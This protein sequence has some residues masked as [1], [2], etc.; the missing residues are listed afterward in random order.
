MATRNIKAGNAYVE[1]GIRNRVAAGAKAVQADLNKLSASLQKHGQSIMRLG[2][3][4]S[5]AMAA[6]L[7][8]AIRAASEMQETMGKFNVV[9][10]EAA[11]NMRQWGEETANAMGVSER[12]MMN[13]LSSMQDL[14]VPMGV[15]PE[16]ARDMSK[17]LSALAVD[18][19]SF[20]NM[21]PDKAFEDL[22][23][24]MTGSGEVMKKYGV[25]LSQ[26]AVNQ[27]LLQNSIDPKVATE[28]EKAQ[29]RLTIIMRGTTAAQGDAIRT[30][31][32]FANRMKALGATLV[33]IT[34]HLGQPLLEPLAHLIGH[35]KAAASGVKD[36]VKENQD[37]V[38]V[39]GMAM[40]AVGGLG[41]ALVGLGGVLQVVGMGLG[42]L[43]AGIGLLI[44]PVGLALGAVTALA[45]GLV[46]YT[47]IGM[48]AIDALAERFGPL[49]KSVQEAVAGISKALQAGDIKG[50]WEILAATLELVWLDLTEELKTSW[51][52]F[53]DFFLDSSTNLI[54]DIGILGTQ[55]ADLL[56]GVVRSLENAYNSFY[57][58]NLDFVMAT[59]NDVRVIGDRVPLTKDDP[60]LQFATNRFGIHS[61]LDALRDSGRLRMDEQRRKK[62]SRDERREA[63]RE[64][65]EM[66]RQELAAQI[67][68]M[69][70]RILPMDPNLLDN[71]TDKNKDEKNKDNEI[72][73]E[74]TKVNDDLADVLKK[75][76]A[77]TSAEFAVESDRGLAT[78]S[79]TFGRTGPSGTFSAFGA[80]VMGMTPP[81]QKVS[82]PE[83]I[84]EQKIANRQLAQMNR[85]LK[86]M[87]G[88]VIGIFAEGN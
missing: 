45:V 70:A 35:M 54:T 6:P 14:L 82:D 72:N 29:A 20:N 26:T 39:G 27:E 85:H 69:S 48:K 1:I 79:P 8:L 34:A 61:G 33:D 4:V 2:G 76:L 40:I 58:K 87:G 53:I 50:A 64:E 86:N 38:R 47:D 11:K 44:S 57:Q 60:G 5:T 9:F 17:E 46:K 12:S 7:A 32:S 43:A 71:Q 51:A 84:K 66:R 37:M 3:A 75:F 81:M 15:A 73:E 16:S 52:S 56:Q 63:E 78:E 55:L 74:L 31:G 42:V 19:A 83:G 36:F 24:A 30:S 41:V 80:M 22:M 62:N 28:A 18:L 88:G 23:A 68:G 21:K 10:G 77:E 49:V 59:Q 25:I 67:K 13:M 65:R